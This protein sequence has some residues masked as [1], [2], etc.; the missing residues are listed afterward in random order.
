MSWHAKY[1]FT[2]IKFLP[3]DIKCFMFDHFNLSS[4]CL[5]SS[6]H[7]SDFL[8]PNW[9]YCYVCNRL[10]F[11]ELLQINIHKASTIRGQ[12]WE[13]ISSMFSFRHMV[14]IC[15]NCIFVIFRVKIPC[16]MLHCQNRG[17][18]NVKYLAPLVYGRHVTLITRGYVLTLWPLVS[19]NG[20]YRPFTNMVFNRDSGMHKESH[21]W[22]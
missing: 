7:I 14:F 19:S 1:E 4:V 17:I 6:I 18:P 15:V 2:E 9:A 20:S 10:L 8:I 13:Q 22:F 16:S 21:P 12:Q 3:C 5:F 11:R